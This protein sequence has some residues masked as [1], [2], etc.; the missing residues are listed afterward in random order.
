MGNVRHSET[1]MHRD[2]QRAIARCPGD[3]YDYQARLRAYVRVNES[4]AEQ[5][6]AVA[7]LSDDDIWYRYYCCNQTVDYLVDEFGVLKDG[8]KL[9]M[10]QSIGQIARAYLEREV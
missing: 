10:C 2:I 1:K 4:N 9:L 7:S 6:A 3:K 8:I 5:I